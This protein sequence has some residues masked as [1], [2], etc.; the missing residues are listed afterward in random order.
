MT[1]EQPQLTFHLYPSVG[2]DDWRYAFSTAKVRAL[3]TEMLSDADIADMVNARDFESALSVLD[4]TEYALTEGGKTMQDMEE[5]LLRRRSEVRKLFADLM[6]DEALA[7]A[8]RVREDFANMRLAVRRTVT[9]RPIGKDY[10]DGGNIAPEDFEEIF[11]HENYALLP[12]PMQKAVEEAVLA[13]YENKDIRQIDYAIERVQT[14]SNLQLAEELG[15]VFL[16]E[17]FRMQI[18]LTNI[19]TML[20]LK[21]RESEERDVF[22]EGGY[23]EI[24]LLKRCLD[25]GYELIGAMFAATPYSKVVEEGVAYLQA[26][27]SFLKL[28]QGCDEHVLGYLKSTN[29]ITAGP[30]PVMAYLLMKEN[31]IRTVRL[32]LTA[33]KNQLDTSLISA[34]VRE[35]E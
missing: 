23:V 2:E 27:G 16:L 3:A 30:Q 14:F 17:L 7:G 6:V 19:R 21:F 25:I 24:S 12:E 8:M 13:Y 34:R 15:S 31:E 29:I 26:N 28:E 1:T 35:Y 32:I 11:E 18:D 9:D 5:L 4:S 20:R 22:F 33:K 10:S